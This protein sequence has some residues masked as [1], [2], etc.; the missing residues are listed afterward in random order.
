MT[1][2][3]L[4]VGNEGKEH[5]G[6]T[7]GRGLIKYDFRIHPRIQIVFPVPEG[8]TETM[9]SALSSEVK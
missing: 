5:L 7:T 2:R 4:L 6:K 3:G 1:S 8:V 9:S